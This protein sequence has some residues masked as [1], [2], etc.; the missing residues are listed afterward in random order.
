MLHC[1]SGYDLQLCGAFLCRALYSQLNIVPFRASSLSCQLED[2]VCDDHDHDDDSNLLCAGPEVAMIA[3]RPSIYLLDEPT[4][5]RS[6]DEP[7]AVRSGSK[8]LFSA[9]RVRAGRLNS[10]SECACI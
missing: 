3:C 6:A 9:N 10:H 2:Y 4:A 7:T 5:V 1:T 8:L